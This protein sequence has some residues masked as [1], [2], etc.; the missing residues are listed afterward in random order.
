[1]KRYRFGDKFEDIDDVFGSVKVFS[2][3]YSLIVALDESEKLFDLA[4]RR[5]RVC[6]IIFSRQWHTEKGRNRFECSLS[7]SCT[8]SCSIIVV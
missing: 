4:L 7:P 5:Y 6:V 8:H 1:M 2:I 3:T